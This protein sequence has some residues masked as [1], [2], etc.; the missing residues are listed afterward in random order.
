MVNG[1][2][3]MVFGSPFTVNRSLCTLGCLPAQAGVTLSQATGGVYPVMTGNRNV[4][5]VMDFDPGS[6]LS[7]YRLQV[8]GW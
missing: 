6:L 2:W 4:I 7:N 3:F 5:I 8:D 1:S